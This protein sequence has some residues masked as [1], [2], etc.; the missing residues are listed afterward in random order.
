MID[1]RLALQDRLR[2]LLKQIDAT[3]A[4]YRRTVK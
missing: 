4:S 1:P 3:I 2:Q